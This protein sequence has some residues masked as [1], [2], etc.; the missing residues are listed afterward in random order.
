[1]PLYISLS[2][3]VSRPNIVSDSEYLISVKNESY[4]MSYNY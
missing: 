3:Y 1:M 4:M 2:V